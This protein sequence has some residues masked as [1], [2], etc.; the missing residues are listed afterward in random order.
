MHLLRRLRR[1]QACQC[2]P[3]LRRR[4]RAAPDPPCA[5]MAGWR[6]RRQA[7]AVGQA[8][9]FE[10]H[11]RRHSRACGTAQGYPAGGALSF[12]RSLRRQDRSL[13]LTEADAIAVALAPAAHRERIAVFQERALDTASQLKRLGAVP[14]DFQKAAALVL[15]RPRDGTAAQEVA[16]IHR[17]A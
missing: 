8:R 15:L 7:S 3:E 5:R 1:D 2:L 13:D 4:L 10:I 6:M 11:A 16:D 14:A 17:A 9:A 12:A